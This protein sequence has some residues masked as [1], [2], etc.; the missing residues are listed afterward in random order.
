MG[1]HVSEHLYNIS[2]ACHNVFVNTFLQNLF[3]SRV[4]IDTKKIFRAFTLGTFSNK[5]LIL[6]Q[7]VPLLHYLLI[8]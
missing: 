7:I 1:V 8:L 3:G 4:A 6:K 2:L 5:K